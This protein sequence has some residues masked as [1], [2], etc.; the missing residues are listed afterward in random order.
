M[1]C[2]ALVRA[3]RMP[4]PTARKA[5]MA[6]WSQGRERT[7]LVA[8]GLASPGQPRSCRSRVRGCRRSSREQIAPSPSAAEHGQ[9]PG[10]S[11]AGRIESPGRGIGPPGAAAGFR[12][13]DGGK[14]PKGSS[15]KASCRNRRPQ[16]GSGNT[17][18]KAPGPA[19]PSSCNCL[20]RGRADGWPRPEKD[21]DV[22][23]VGPTLC[24]QSDQQTGAR[25]RPLF[26]PDWDRNSMGVITKTTSL[27]GNSMGCI[28]F[29]PLSD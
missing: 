11:G 20:S 1:P 8:L 19:V 17:A 13:W 18:A 14:G 12:S 28:S 6:A 5:A 2:I 29:W 3:E 15:R 23:A 9:N 21:P 22:S 24:S 25:W 16:Q 7:A 26:G 10:R 27:S 4:S